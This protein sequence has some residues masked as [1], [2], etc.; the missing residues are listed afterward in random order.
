MD[1]KFIERLIE[2]IAR[3]DVAE[4]AYSTGDSR[5]RLGRH[6]LNNPGAAQTVSARPPQDALIPAQT[7]PTDETAHTVSSG[8][9]G[10]FYRSASPDTPP[11]VEVGD[12]VE[13]GQTLA[14]VEAMK[15][16]NPIEADRRGRILAIPGIDGAMI[17]AGS[18]LF[19]LEAMDDHA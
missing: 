14:I 4:L 12:V 11:F 18:P 9:A 13:E 15:M 10:V 7:V 16:L 1:L 17:E 6:G 3:S 8:L 5:I 2:L 19:T